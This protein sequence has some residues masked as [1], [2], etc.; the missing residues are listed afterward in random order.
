MLSFRFSQTQDHYGV[1]GLTWEATADKVRKA[2]HEK[3][4]DVDNEPGADIEKYNNAYQVLID[5]E[6]KE[7]YDYAVKFSQ[8][9][10]LIS[11]YKNNPEQQ[12]TLSL[13]S[14]MFDPDTGV[15]RSIAYIAL[16]KQVDTLFGQAVITLAILR[17]RGTNLKTIIYERLDCKDQ[18]SAETSVNNLIHQIAVDKD[19]GFFESTDE[20]VAEISKKADSCGAIVD[21]EDEV[22]K[23]AK[24][25]LPNGP[26]P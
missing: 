7:I 23:I 16:F 3:I 26:R 13:A 2:Y 4:A 5:P 6:Q 20:I 14:R 25:E 12:S 9:I 17:G 18:A 1:L 15:F 24:L 11:D 21:F 10:K 22:L 8:L 19:A